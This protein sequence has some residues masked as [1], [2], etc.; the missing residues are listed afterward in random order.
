[1]RLTSG[2]RSGELVWTSEGCKPDPLNGGFAVTTSFEQP[3]YHIVAQGGTNRGKEACPDQC[4][5]IPDGV[6]CVC[7]PRCAS[8]THNANGNS[9]AH[10]C[11]ADVSPQQLNQQLGGSCNNVRDCPHTATFS[12]SLTL[13]HHAQV[14]GY[15]G[16]LMAP[17][18][19]Y[20]AQAAW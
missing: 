16:Q 18:T 4:G 12:S 7:T 2:C 10:R 1:M 13:L 6:R 19:L 8:D 14:Q 9:F 5:G 3:I 15:T 17:P 11:C 20:G